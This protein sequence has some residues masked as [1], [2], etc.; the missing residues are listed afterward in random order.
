[1]SKIKK[2]QFIS[3][4][5]YVESIKKNNIGI[6]EQERKNRH[7]GYWALGGKNLVNTVKIKTQLK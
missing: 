2:N 1:M 5:F 7:K 4:V 3:E 6:D